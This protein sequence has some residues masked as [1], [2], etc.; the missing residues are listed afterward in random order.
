MT[1]PG[2]EDRLTPHLT[3]GAGIAIAGIWLA[4]ASLTALLVMVAFVWA[5]ERVLGSDPE[6][7]DG[8]W[9]LL[10]LLALPMLAGIAST[11]RIL[12]FWGRDD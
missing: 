12:G 11:R 1:E 8:F 2:T 5:P 3:T 4:A 7:S 9:L 6:A 10:L